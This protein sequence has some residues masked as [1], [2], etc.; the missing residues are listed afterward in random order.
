MK[1]PLY[2]K[3]FAH[4]DSQRVQ[5]PVTEATEEANDWMEHNYEKVELVSHEVTVTHVPHGSTTATLCSVV[6]KYYNVAELANAPATGQTQKLDP[7]I[8]EAALAAAR[9]EPPFSPQ[10]VRDL[11]RTIN[12]AFV[13]SSA[14]QAQQWMNHGVEQFAM[15]LERG[16]CLAPGETL[17]LMYELIRATEQQ[18]RIAIENGIYHGKVH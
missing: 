11:E 5:A 2:I 10:T 7:A 12:L 17:N 15:A 4:E 8:A 1:A 18:V 14:E 6:I 13:H 3:A 9:N 16:D